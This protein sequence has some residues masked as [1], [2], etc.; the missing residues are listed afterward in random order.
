MHCC[1]S[2][3]RY[4]AAPAVATHQAQREDMLQDVAGN[5]RWGAAAASF[6]KRLD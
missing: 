4:R 3:V 6:V 5:E 2:L 1:C